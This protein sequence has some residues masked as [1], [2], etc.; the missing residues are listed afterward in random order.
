MQP[1]ENLVWSLVIQDRLTNQYIGKTR[2]SQ[3]DTY[4]LIENGRRTQGK[5][6][7]TT[8]LDPTQNQTH[9]HKPKLYSGTDI[10]TDVNQNW[11]QKQ[12]IGK[13]HKPNP[14]AYNRYLPQQENPSNSR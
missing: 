6:K 13:K 12:K 8:N 3:L 2:R 11:T 1:T 4:V 14:N 7:G 9:G 5:K 10:E